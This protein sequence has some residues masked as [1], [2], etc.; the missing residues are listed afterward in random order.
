MFLKI[1]RV[2]LL[3]CAAIFV[4]SA[5]GA[6]E[7]AKWP[8]QGRCIDAARISDKGFAPALQAT[9]CLVEFFCVA[10]LFSP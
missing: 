1:G 4:L 8:C 9:K 6:A 3:I 7:P 5:G 10:D 2:C